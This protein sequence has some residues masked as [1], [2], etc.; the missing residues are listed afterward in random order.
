MEI[1]FHWSHPWI[2]PRRHLQLFL[3]FPFLLFL[4]FLATFKIYFLSVIFYS[5]SVIL[6]N[7]IRRW[8]CSFLNVSYSW[9][10]LNFS[11][12]VSWQFSPDFKNFEPLVLQ[13]SFYSTPPWRILNLVQICCLNLF[14]GSLVLPIPPPLYFL[15][16]YHLG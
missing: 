5:L 3:S 6:S 9:G 4:P 14:H 12:S 13:K 1:L 7:L 10:S 11:G 15:S 16:V 8:W 2:I